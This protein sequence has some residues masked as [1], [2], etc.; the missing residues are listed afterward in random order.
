MWFP[1]KHYVLYRVF[2]ISEDLNKEKGIRSILR[3]D[4]DV[5]P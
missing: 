2:N 4:D 1:Q 5:M 3:G